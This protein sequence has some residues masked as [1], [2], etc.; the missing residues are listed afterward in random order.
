MQKICHMTSAHTSLDT[1]IFYKQCISLAEAGF[2]TYLVAPGESFEQNGVKVIGVETSKG[3]RLLR[4]TK[5]AKD[6][7][8]AALAVDAD[9]YQLHDPELLQFALKLKKKGKKVIFDSHEDY[10]ENIRKKTWIPFVIRPV[11][12]GLYK[13]YQNHVLKRIDAVIY[14]T[15]SQREKLETVNPNAVMITNYP[16]IESMEESPVYSGNRTICFAGGISEQ[17]MHENIIKAAANKGIKYILCGRETT[18]LSYLKTLPEWPIVDYKGELPHDRVF[19]VLREAGIGMALA[20]DKLY[21]NY[22]TLGNTKLFEE[23]LAG[24]PVICTNFILWKEIIEDNNCG[25]CV[26]PNDIDSIAYAINYLFDNPGVAKQMGANG[27]KMVIEKYNWSVEE[28][29]LLNLYEHLISQK[30]V[31]LKYEI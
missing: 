2:E 21:G 31:D 12:A 28:K 11:I 20:D 18:Y 25:I 26:D 15:L 8:R 13:K 6:V 9:I 14:V 16:I 22:G 23:M 19:A 7:Y 27:R 29:K 17:W 10:P 4:M 1:R 5:I 30:Y 3:N 24:I